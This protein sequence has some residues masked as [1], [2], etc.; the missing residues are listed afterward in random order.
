MTA[1]RPLHY[2]DAC[3]FISVLQDERLPAAVS[4]GI[5]EISKQAERG[6]STVVTSVVSR[7]EVL[8]CKMPGAASTK[9]LDLFRTKAYQMINVD[10]RIADLAHEI[11][12][13]AISSG[14]KMTQMDAIHLATAIYYDVSEL[15]T[16]DGSGKKR[17]L[18]DFDG[19]QIGRFST[20]R[21]CSPRAAQASL[22]T[23]A[24]PLQTEAPP[25]KIRLIKGKDTTDS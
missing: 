24:A 14:K 20:L 22:L 9:F 15:N 23:G 1:T 6:Q 11:R 8:D 18:I 2:W 17:G 21:V 10:H 19:L 3:I 4:E 13:A 25:K 16:L 12:N 5:E 7:I